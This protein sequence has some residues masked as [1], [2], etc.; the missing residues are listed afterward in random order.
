MANI[1][2]IVFLGII[3]FGLLVY[4]SAPQAP[5][6][7][8]KEASKLSTQVTYK[9]LPWQY[10]VV[11]TKFYTKKDELFKNEVTYLIVLNHEGLALA[12][13]LNALAD[14]NIL[15]LANISKTPWLIK[16]LAVNGKLEELAKGSEISL[17]NDE[18]GRIVK[19]LNLDDNLSTKYFVYKISNKKTV[20][21][22]YE[23]KIKEGALEYGL[24]D[25]ELKLIINELS[26]KLQ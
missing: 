3:G 21:K 15:L 16:K 7:K 5:G 11:G 26:S 4:L 18:D 10:E 1:L 25:D 23:G 2:K 22:I 12:N 20:E 13:K 17:I 19:S 6:E 9:S 14:K 8:N 24:K